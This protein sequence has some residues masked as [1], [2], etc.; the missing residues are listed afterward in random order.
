MKRFWYEVHRFVCFF[1]LIGFVVTCCMLLFLQNLQHSLQIVF[2]QQHIETAAK[3]TFINVVVITLVFMLVDLLWRRL[4][5]QRRAAEISHAAQKCMAG[6]FSVRISRSNKPD[7]AFDIIADSF[8]L[9]AEELA[10]TETLRK[11]F[12][13][14]VSHELKSPLAVI[15]NY[16][17][18]LQNPVLPEDER[19]NYLKVISSQTERMAALVT[20]I[21]KLSKLENQ[22]IHPQNK[23]FDLGEHL[24]SCLLAFE[25]AWEKKELEIETD[26]QD[27]VLVRSD[28]ELLGIVWNNLFSNAVKFTPQGGRIFLSLRT[29]GEEA[30]VEVGDTGCGFGQEAGRHLFE[31]FYQGDP[32]HASEGNGLGLALVKRVVEIVGGEISAQSVL[33]EGS[34]FSVR[35]RRATKDETR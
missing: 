29:D 26:L 22:Q 5:V 3:S 11:D 17:A 6:D 12:V 27:D 28:E 8:N 13:A 4:H 20:N 31:K 25:D 15:R 21:L 23:C 32:S 1:L 18:L 19:R 24:C 2:T 16:A 34:I 33:G 9:M 14:N 30:V 35:I 10:G 7:D